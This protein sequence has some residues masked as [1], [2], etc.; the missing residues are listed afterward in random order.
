[1]I[2]LKVQHPLPTIGLDLYQLGVHTRAKNRLV[3]CAMIVVDI[4]RCERAPRGLS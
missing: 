4:L 2:P 1:M 3:A